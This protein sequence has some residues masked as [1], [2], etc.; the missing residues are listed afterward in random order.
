MLV[1]VIPR[2]HNI[3][4]QKQRY[5]TLISCDITMD[6]RSK[7]TLLAIEHNSNEVT[8]LQVGSHRL[9]TPWSGCGLFRSEDSDD[10]DK[11]GTAIGNNTH[12]NKLEIS[13]LYHNVT[14]NTANKR[15]YEGIR[16]NSSISEVMF[17]SIQPFK[18]RYNCIHDIDSIC[19]DVA[20]EVLRACKERI[21]LL[22][23]LSTLC[24]W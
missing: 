22:N 11:L 19:I 18:M 10:Y 3:S 13:N 7:D 8:Y 20:F 21:S 12:L 15:F 24:P 9:E 6:S 1:L 16:H 23:Y 2:V 14:L 4:H 17:T 5:Q